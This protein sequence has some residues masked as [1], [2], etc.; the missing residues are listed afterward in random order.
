M[1]ARLHRIYGEWIT[2]G[3]Q[4]LLLFVGARIGTPQGWRVCVAL[5]A[6]LSVQAWV[7]VLRRARVI[8]DTPTSTVAS[9]AQG[10][11]ELRGRGQPL[12]GMP[13]MSPINGLPCLWFR[14]KVECKRGDRWEVESSGQSDASFL[15]DDGSGQCVVD[16]EGAEILPAR[17][18]T[19][20]EG[21]RRYTQ[22]LLLDRESIYV[23]GEFRTWG[24]DALNL[25]VA[26]DMK[27]LLAAWK[28]DMPALLKRY[29]LDGN[30]SLDL[31]EWE[32]ARAQARREVERNH[33][34][35]RAA[36]DTQLMGR[37]RDGR[38]YLISSLTEEKLVR[39]FR[40]WAVAHVVIFFG[41]LVGLTR[42]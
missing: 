35:L 6:V 20:T 19:W 14:Y 26:E 4:L 42:I 1:L 8:A 5:I 38:L 24:G 2:S 7:S 10:Y 9:A 39:R 34:E 23:L 11:V 17:R 21:E 27:V 29:D 3:G 40:W 22:W 31:R 32:L 30:G 41:A 18:D 36:P 16:P 28:R 13:V 33:R 12:P 15:L 37:P 25:N